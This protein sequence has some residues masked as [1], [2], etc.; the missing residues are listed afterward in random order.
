MLDSLIVA[1]M[2]LGAGS[3]SGELPFWATSNRYGL[4]PQYNGGAAVLNARTEFDESRTLQWRAGMSF[5][6]NLESAVD[7]ASAGSFSPRGAGILDEMY[8]SCRW[9]VFTLDVGMKHREQDFLAS[10][11]GFLGSLSSTS[12]NIAW[13]SNARS[14]PGY[15]I[16]LAPVEVPFTNG[17]FCIYGRYGDYKTLDNRFVDGALVHNMQVGALFH[18]GDRLDFRFALDHYA[19]WGGVSPVYGK[20]P[21][22]LD[23]YIRMATGR[24]AAASSGASE[25]DKINVIGDQRGAELFRFDWR[26]DGWTAT[27]QHD[28]PYDDGSGMGFSNF[29]DGVNTL[30]FGWN[31]KDRL[32]SDILCEFAYTIWQSGTYHDKLVDGKAVIY[33]GLDNYFNNDGYKSGWTLYGRTIGMPMMFPKGTSDHTWRQGDLT[34]GVENNRVKYWHCGIA[35]KLFRKAPYKLLFT[36]SKNYGLYKA[37]YRGESQIYKEWGT[38]KE[39][40]VPQ[41]SAA[42]EGEIP[43]IFGVG[44]LTLDYGVYAD[45]GE[46]LRNSFGALIGLRVKI[47]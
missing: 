20:M 11:D 28:I 40:P 12:G 1:L 44:R 13:S 25:S 37:P 3:T 10:G 27:F 18:I 8:G 33:G 38:V 29:P 4:M 17:R 16:T 21:F 36:A 26:G 42:F 47:Y 5:A 32:V 30:H 14:L 22:T 24:S 2:L 6:A 35:G 46:V 7:N 15:T 45:R 9:K 31:D 41:F 39:T 19:L 23:N 43:G 34:L